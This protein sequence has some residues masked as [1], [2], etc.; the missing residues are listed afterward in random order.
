MNYL[1]LLG[2]AVLFVFVGLGTVGGCGGSGDGDGNGDLAG[3]INC[4]DGID[5]DGDTET[6]CSDIDCILDP[7]C[8]IPAP[9]VLLTPINNEIIQQN[10][11]NIG[12]PFDPT[13]GF[14]F[15][16]SYDW[17]DASS[18]NGIN[19]YHLFVKSMTAMFPLIDIFVLDSNFTDTSCNTFVIDPNLNDWIWTVQ[20][21]DNMG[22]L[23]P[24]AT[25]EFMFGPCR[26]DDGT[27]CNAPP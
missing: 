16:I 27:P 6:D 20:A 1:R 12:C 13:S 26:L 15:R 2:I 22:I 9:V 21:E 7:F 18:P 10:N 11:P 25:G 14:G 19:G 8:I 23:S 17:T 5:N 4:T 3:E 24:V